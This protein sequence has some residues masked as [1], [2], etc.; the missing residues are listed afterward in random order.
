MAAWVLPA[1]SAGASIL[2]S[3][4]GGSSAAKK[5]KK[6][7]AL[8]DEQKTKNQAWYNNRYNEDYTQTAAAQSAL[9]AAKQNLDD[10]YK[11]T[12]AT[13]A[14]TGATG[15]TVAQQKAANNAALANTAATIAAQ[16]TSRKDSI[17]SQYL[18]ADNTFTQQQSNNLMGQATNI[19]NAAGQASSTLG[20]LAGVLAQ[21]KSGSGN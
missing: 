9:N 15:T 1:I 4:F 18:Q 6:A 8:I 10:Q 3:V 17:E 21:M 12:A 5:A 7:N 16:G 13:A 19:S 20:S 11:K 2:S 14:V